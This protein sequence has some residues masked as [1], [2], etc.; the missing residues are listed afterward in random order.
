MS[1]KTKINPLWP[2][3]LGEGPVAVSPKVDFPALDHAV[4]D[5]WKQHDVFQ[6]SIFE[7]EGCKDF[8]AYDGPPGTNGVPHIGHMMQSALKDLW[9]RYKTMQG[10]RVLRKAGWDTHGLP[11]ELTAE[12]DLNVV[13]KRDIEEK[14]GV[15]KYIDHCRSVVFRYRDEWIKAINRIGR[16]L[17]T[18]NDYATFRRE[19]IE[20]DWWVLKQAWDKGLLYQDRRIMPYCSRCGTSLSQHEVA[21]GY[22]D[23]QDITIY[24]KFPIVGRDNTYFVA[25]TTTPW[26]LLSNVAL[27]VNPDL[28]YVLVESASGER[29][30][31][32]EARLEALSSMLGQTELIAKN[33]GHHLSS[34]KYHPLWDFQQNSDA[35]RVITDDYVTADDGTGIVHLALYGSDDFRLI[36]AN[37]LPQ[38]QNVDIDGKV[39]ANSGQF[40]GRWFKE[41]GLDIDILKDLATRGLLF[42]KEKITHSYPHCYRCYTPLMY[43]AK[44]GWFLRTSALKEEMLAANAKINWFPEHIKEG[45]FGNWLENNVDWNISRDRYWGSPIPI[46]SC[47]NCGHQVCVESLADLGRRLKSP[48]SA[49]GVAATLVAGLPDDFDPHKPGIDAL[50]MACENC[51]GSMKRT[52]EVLDCWFNAGIMPWGQYGKETFGSTEAKEQ[53]QNDP[54][55]FPAD[56][57]CEAIDQTRGWFYT[58]LATS[59]LVTTRK[60]DDGTFSGGVSSFKNVICSEFITD[61]E[62]RKMSKSKGNVIDPLGLCEKFGADAI[63]WSFYNT[64]PWTARRFSEGDLTEVLKQ[65]LIPYWNAYSFFVTYARVDGWKPVALDSDARPTKPNPLD[66]WILSRLVSLD[67]TVRAALDGYD[68]MSAAQAFSEYLDDLTNWHIRR[69][70]R[71]FWKSEDDDDKQWAYRV[72]HHVLTT[73]NRMLAPF[74]PFVSEAVYQNIERGFDAS[75]PDS[76]HLANWPKVDPTMRDVSLEQ[77]ID[78]ARQIV[79]MA[80]SLRADNSVRVRQP[81]RELAVSMPGVSA[82][83]T[84]DPD[85]EEM[86]LDELNIKAL[87]RV[88]EPSDLFSWQAKG[89]MKALGPKYGSRMK[90]A[91]AVVA[92]L[93]HAKIM[94]LLNNGKLEVDGLTLSKEDLLL[95]QQPADGFWVRS[96]GNLT[97]AIGNQMDKELNQEWLAR[98]F[99]HHVQ[100]LRRDA[101]LE[102]TDRIAI[103]YCGD[104][105]LRDA[106]IHHVRYVASETLA[107]S[108][109]T[110]LD[111]N[112]TEVR[113]GD[114][115][116][117]V[118]IRPFK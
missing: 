60:A 54:T 78:Q 9:P 91:L 86:I 25:W 11:I 52:P 82:S 74:M 40:A 108:I 33:V 49:A 35:H 80:R 8:V 18:E 83:D 32:A 16:F 79:S 70:R 46:W 90:D 115:S 31:V 44:S 114:K 107:E 12:K 118:K 39:T 2:S 101:G 66:R 69:S 68:V 116:C 106:W 67:E 75:L 48:V 6:R 26:T 27:A 95:S 59:V 51:G 10:H 117:R 100:T 97:V 37:N 109:V 5:H 21:Q 56:F 38:V 36:R 4:L 73:M 81:L 93:D 28:N 98:E 102:V 72:L 1:N 94:E 3:T 63:R 23:V 13:T 20:T 99:I 61:P 104:R 43:F 47:D 88:A 85:L 24:A 14:V 50:E 89:D 41:D 92:T 62:G 45:R 30:I 105:D 53:I 113:I 55:R 42:G 15:Q 57:I 34:L 17:D 84:F 77:Q 58:M 87:R 71:R 111:S 110:T 65:V 22:K 76:V 19:Y 96:E 64:N 7:R 29:L 103:D 112:A